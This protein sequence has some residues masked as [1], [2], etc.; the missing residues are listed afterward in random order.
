MEELFSLITD[1]N[2]G[3]MKFRGK[4]VA[5]WNNKQYY[6]FQ[7]NF[8][9]FDTPFAYKYNLYTDMV[10]GDVEWYEKEAKDYLV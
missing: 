8:A 3:Q 5:A 2:S 6:V 10:T 1:P 9:T 4:Q 7:A